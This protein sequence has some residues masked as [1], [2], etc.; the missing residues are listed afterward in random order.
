MAAVYPYTYRKRSSP[1]PKGKLQQRRS[2]RRV[3]TNGDGFRLRVRSIVVGPRARS[4]R[5]HAAETPI[6]SRIGTSSAALKKTRRVVPV[7]CIPTVLVLTV[8]FRSG[9]QVLSMRRSFQ[10]QVVRESRVVYPVRR[11]TPR[12]TAGQARGVYI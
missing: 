11:S 5:E 8:S 3:V 1:R 12:E 4:T 9:A 10:V 7:S 2:H 6:H